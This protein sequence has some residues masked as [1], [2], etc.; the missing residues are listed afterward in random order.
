MEI[1]GP[2]VNDERVKQSEGPLNRITAR[3]NLRLV[4]K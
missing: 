2:V 3:Q 4:S 1:S